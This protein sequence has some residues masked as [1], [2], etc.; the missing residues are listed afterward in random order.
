MKNRGQW[1]AIVMTEICLEEKGRERAE[2]RLLRG[3][4]CKV[5]NVKRKNKKGRSMGGMLMGLRKELITGE[6]VRIDKEDE[7][8]G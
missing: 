8:E 6:E 2:G 3:Y 5:Q 1:E 4:R 7:K